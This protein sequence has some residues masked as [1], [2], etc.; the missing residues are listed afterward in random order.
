[1]PKNKKKKVKEEE[2]TPA[3][4]DKD[5]VIIDLTEK[6]TPIAN[7][8]VEVQIFIEP[9]SIRQIIEKFPALSWDYTNRI[10]EEQF[11][12]AYEAALRELKA[13]VK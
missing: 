5:E 3:F 1:M 7:T 6:E 2:K 4:N 8:S 11:R 10:I 13:L 12:P 9:A